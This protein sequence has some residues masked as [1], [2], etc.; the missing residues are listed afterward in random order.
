VLPS[1]IV[2]TLKLSKWTVRQRL[3][4]GL[5]LIL[6]LFA[7]TAGVSLWATHRINRSLNVLMT[8]A[9]QRREAT[10][11]M[12]SE[13]ARIAQQAR[14]YA[15]AGDSGAR[16]QLEKAQKSF[17]QAL[18]QYKDHASTESGRRAAQEAAAYHERLKRKTEELDRLMRQRE[19]TLDD[20]AAQQRNVETVLNSM[21][22]PAAQPRQGVPV[23]KV[24]L[25]KDLTSQLHA[26]AGAFGDGMHAQGEAL[27]ARA[28]RERIK[29]KSLL[30]RYRALADTAA[31]RAW[32]NTAENWYATVAKHARTL[33]AGKAT[34]QRILGQIGATRESIDGLLSNSMQPATRAELAAA[35]E[36]ASIAAREAIVAVTHALILAFLLAGLAAL[37]TMRAVRAPLGRLVASSKRLVEGDLS[38]RISSASPGELGELSSA[39]NTMAEKLEATTLSRGYLGSIVASMGEALVV[40]SRTGLI[41][42]ANPAVERMLGYQPGQ[43]LDR[44][45]RSIVANVAEAL[46]IKTADAPLRLITRLLHRDGFEIPVSISAV[47]MSSQVDTG[48]AVVCIAQDLRERITAQHQQRQADVVLENTKE[49]IV[50]TDANGAIVLVNPAFTDITLYT[51]AEAKGTVVQ[52]LWSNRDDADAGFVERM[53]T[54]VKEHGQWQG[55]IWLRRKTG[56]LRPVWK[57]ISAVRDASESIANFVMVFSDISAM[58]EAEERLNN[59]AYYDALTKLPNRLLFG[60][61]LQLALERSKRSG[62]SVA[63]LYVDLDGFKH[64]NDTLG[65][66]EGDRLLQEMAARLPD[67]VRASGAVARLGGD[68][69]VVVLEDIAR[70]QHAARIAERILDVISAPFELSGL[71]L[72]MS[73]SIGISLS[74]LHGST[75]DELLKAADAAM[76]RAK[77]EGGRSY[78]FFSRELTKQ[79]MEQLTLRNAL[80]HPDLHEQLVVHYQPQVS[81]STGCI[82][83][84]EALVRWQHPTQGL[85][86]PNQFMPIAE[87]AGLAHIIGDWVLQAACVQARA[88][89]QDGKPPLR[90]AVNVSAQEIRTQAIVEKVARVLSATGLDA[91]LLEL[92]VTEGALQTGDEIVDV[93][94]KLRHMGVHLALDDFGAGY[95]SLGSIRSLP[96]HRLKI[97]RSFVRDLPNDVNDRS[98][99]RAIIAMGRSLNLEILAEGVESLAQ[100]K[101]LRDEGCHEIQG[102]LMGRPMPAEALDAEFPDRLARLPAAGP[103]L[104][105]PRRHTPHAGNAAS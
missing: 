104:V 28:E 71:E 79:A 35:A 75:T 100:L 69:F 83:G 70:P 97:D 1:I 15:D 19:Q 78:Q 56:E 16:S 31:E 82:V 84:V 5:G 55:E 86:S 52:A 51:A 23:R 62:K 101:I 57:N 94:G 105:R 81:L 34:E 22:V 58:K 50:L 60:E 80:R 14:R 40:V 92:E 68:E 95:S 48:A 9:D 61:R 49:G 8:G 77:R 13:L 93:L 39:F 103:H 67:F 63:L 4:L 21:P 10:S 3:W 76:Y 44:P 102:F 98:I 54:S 37:V 43:L 45:F 25:E 24:A 90:V 47:P 38:H 30:A 41:H 87:E 72:R 88:W 2:G 18:D 7:I 32:A 33:V 46:Q 17:D 73:A 11:A 91:S 64:V 36:S 89:Q 27:S 65:H 6:L 29:L 74:P 59:L 96:F 12:K 53:W 66:Q 20:I 85:L 99:A 42:T 26:A